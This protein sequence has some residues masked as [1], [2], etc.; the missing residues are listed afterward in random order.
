[1][2]REQGHDQAQ[3]SQT[4]GCQCG[5]VR[6]RLSAEPQALFICHCRECQKQSASAFGI[7]VIMASHAVTLL[8][9]NLKSWTRATDSGRVLTCFFCPDCGTRL[10]HGDKDK[11]PSVSIK[12]GSLDQPP[13]LS[14]AVHIW[15]NRKLSGVI[16]PPEAV[17]F[18][19]EPPPD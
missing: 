18:A 8:S 5:Q 3:Q 4:G 15:V 17:C 13:D 6:Y 19:A 14:K 2:Q 9:G 11:A 16:V 7:S 10:W 12:G 1:M